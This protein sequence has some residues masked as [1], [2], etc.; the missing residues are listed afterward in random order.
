MIVIK[1]FIYGL[2]WFNIRGRSEIKC[3]KNVIVAE[4]S[5]SSGIKG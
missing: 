1:V 5:L 4:S 3:L 2:G